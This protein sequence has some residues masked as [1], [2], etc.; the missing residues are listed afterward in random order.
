MTSLSLSRNGVRPYGE[1]LPPSPHLLRTRPR[2][3]VTPQE[4]NK[5]RDKTAQGGY[6][7]EVPGCSTSF[8]KGPMGLVEPSNTLRSTKHTANTTI[9]NTTHGTAIGLRPHGPPKPPQCRHIYGTR[10]VCELMNKSSTGSSPSKMIFLQ[11]LSAQ[12]A[13]SS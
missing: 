12:G 10:S 5:R 6:S 8:N 2:F 3:S 11:P 7:W 9:P 1:K 4:K 13:H